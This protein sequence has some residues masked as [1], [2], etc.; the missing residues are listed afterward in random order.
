MRKRNHKMAPAAKA[1]SKFEVVFEGGMYFVRRDG[2]RIPGS[3]GS[4]EDART[5]KERL[6]KGDE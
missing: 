5:E 6:E 3:Y 4:L 2:A 1:G